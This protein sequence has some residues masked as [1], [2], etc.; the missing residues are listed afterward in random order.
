MPAAIPTGIT[1]PGRQRARLACDTMPPDEK[2]RSDAYF[3]GGYWLDSMEFSAHRRDCT[4]LSN[5]QA[6]RAAFRDLAAST[7]EL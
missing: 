4:L 5:H 1:D 3:E 7:N 6:F 2:A